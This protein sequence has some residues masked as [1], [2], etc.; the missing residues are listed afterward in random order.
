MR[1]SLSKGFTLV[2]LL[3]VII[4]I[5]TLISLLLPA[6]Q[7]A[8]KAARKSSLLSDQ[9]DEYE[10]PV[11]RSKTTGQDKQLPQA[12]V[13]S[14]TAEVTLTPKLSVGT[15]TTE[16]IYEARFEGK[17]KARSPKTESVES[18]EIALPLPPKIISLADLSIR[19]ADQA[20]ENI[21]VSNGELIWRGELP[22]ESTNLDV[23]YSAVGKGLYKLALAPGGLLDEYNVAVTAKGSD[24]RLLNL[25][26]QPT[27]LERKNG[28]SVYRWDYKRLL[29]GR[30]VHVDVLGI[31][32]IDQ[33]GELTWLGPLSVVL[34]GLLVGLVVQATST[35][36][37]DRWILLLTI[38]TFSGAYPLMYFAQEYL[39]LIPA[40]IASG[41][42]ALVIIGIR[43]LTLM[44]IWKGLFGITMPAILIMAMTL[45]ATVWP[46]MQ[47]VI[48]TIMLLGFFVAAMMLMPKV[49]KS[50]SH[51]WT[52]PSGTGG[53]GAQAPT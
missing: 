14:F 17:I 33:L 13:N 24:V 31:A 27:A 2:E 11:S 38:G 50:G 29:F 49:T 53:S 26:L 9:Y 6:V 7:S 8:R 51:F 32:P 46:Q 12:R 40:V 22:P 48:L 36:S 18:C 1:L 3:V 37:F 30:P 16:S 34:F 15:A 47:G 39:S 52:L 20:S 23:T 10:P 44:G 45:L 42:L 28:S 35:T 41:A 43:A 25:S 4:I 21:A 19:V 5:A